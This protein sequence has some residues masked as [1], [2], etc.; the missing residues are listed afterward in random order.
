MSFLTCLNHV[1]K[2][3]CISPI[4]KKDIPKGNFERT[5]KETEMN[6][7]ATHSQKLLAHFK[8]LQGISIELQGLLGSEDLA[9]KIL[10]VLKS[11]LPMDGIQFWS[12]PSSQEFARLEASVGRSEHGNSALHPSLT[13]DDSI[14]AYVFKSKKSLLLETIP[15]RGPSFKHRHQ[16]KNGIA[17]RSSC[18]PRK[19]VS[20]GPCH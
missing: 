8:L 18:P 9:Q 1:K 4:G 3:L 2:L 6:S 13:P 7:S 16:P 14:L 12:L 19:R 20:R 5:S 10:H 15:P 17:L 11:K